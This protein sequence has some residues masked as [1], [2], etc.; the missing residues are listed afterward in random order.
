MNGWAQ[1]IDWTRSLWSWL[2]GS[3]KRSTRTIVAGRVVL[4]RYI[5][6]DRPPPLHWKDC[7]PSTRRRFKAELTCSRGHAI[8]LKAHGICSDGSVQPSIVCLHP[9]C[10]FHEFVRL[11][12]WT[13]G[14]LSR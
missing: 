6:G 1:F 3:D 13:A 12:G 9:R 11:D 8:S 10:D 14:A 2:K 7:H 5:G 4:P